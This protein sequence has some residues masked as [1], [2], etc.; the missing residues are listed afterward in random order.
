VDPLAELW[1]AFEQWLVE[2]PTLTANELLERLL[3]TSPNAAISRGQLRTLQRRV[4][5]WRADRAKFLVLGQHARVIEP[6][7]T[8]EQPSA[9]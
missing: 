2:E 8:T 6:V 9:P 4:K 5:V 1:P 7:T 3:T